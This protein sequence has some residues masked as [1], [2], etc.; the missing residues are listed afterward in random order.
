MSIASASARLGRTA[1]AHEVLDQSRAIWEDKLAA[2]PNS[3]IA[4]SDVAD[5]Y[6]TAA[7]VDRNDPKTSVSLYRKALAPADR[8]AA[9]APKD[10]AVAFRQVKALEGL[11]AA[12]DKAGASLNEANALRRRLVEL[13]TAW[14]ALQ[15]GS[16]FIQ[17]RLQLAINLAP[18]Q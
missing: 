1:E 13:W 9:L 4:L 7:D 10:F 12:L 11:A 17:N 2:R 6:L 3:T 15:P 14:D 18:A 16:S 5:F 8:A